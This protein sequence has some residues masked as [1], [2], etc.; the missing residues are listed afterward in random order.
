M[1]VTPFRAVRPDP[2]LAAAISVP[3]Y[4][5]V[6]FDEIKNEALNPKSFFHVTRSEIDLPDL[7]SPYVQRV[8]DKSAEALKSFVKQGWLVQDPK[9]S[10]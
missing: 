2:H 6:T 10:F 3:P 8:Y 1:K 9:E 7:K 4:D 5:V